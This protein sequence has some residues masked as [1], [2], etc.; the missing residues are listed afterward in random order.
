MAST[1]YVPVTWLVQ[2]TGD[3]IEELTLDNQLNAFGPGTGQ[4]VM[5]DGVAVLNW[6]S[7]PDAGSI[8][9]NVGDYVDQ[10]GTVQPQA[11]IEGSFRPVSG[12]SALG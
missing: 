3:N 7:V 6:P 9:I 8:V 11:W 5:K 12:L 2:F 4:V 10:N 1:P